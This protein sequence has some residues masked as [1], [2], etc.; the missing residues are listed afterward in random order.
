MII[1]TKLEK[2]VA[3]IPNSSKIKPEAKIPKLS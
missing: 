1:T 2:N 3:L